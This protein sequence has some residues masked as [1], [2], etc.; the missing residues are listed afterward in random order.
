M[1]I[2]YAKICNEGDLIFLPHSLS[3]TQ[4]GLIS[5]TL[6]CHN[7][8][9]NKVQRHEPANTEALYS[10]PLGSAH[11]LGYFQVIAF[12]SQMHLSEFCIGSERT[13]WLITRSMMTTGCIVGR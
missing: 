10:L 8:M 7:E 12:S 2:D 4:H 6:I 5:F 9:S 11:N 3:R 1:G 13:P